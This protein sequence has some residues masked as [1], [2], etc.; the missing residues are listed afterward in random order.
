MFG[1]QLSKLDTGIKDSSGSPEWSW[2]VTS[3]LTENLS[4]FLLSFATLRLCVEGLPRLCFVITLDNCP[5]P[6]F[7]YTQVRQFVRP[8]VARI[9]RVAFDPDPIDF[10]QGAE[11]IELL[12]Q[13]HVLDGLLV[14][15]APASPFPIVD[16][17][18]D[19]FLNVLR[20][21][22]Q[23]NFAGALERLECAD[24]RSQLHAVVGRAR[25]TAVHLLHMVSEFQQGAPTARAGVSLAGTVG[26][27]VSYTHLTLPTNREV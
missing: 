27:A 10:V 3:A 22:V 7:F 23:T 2:V 18:A 26:I 9:S 14:G 24:D 16:P 8:L 17:D 21:G 1:A 13:V 6:D 5:A 25:L 11:G 19:A 12:P 4:L 15:C 20:I